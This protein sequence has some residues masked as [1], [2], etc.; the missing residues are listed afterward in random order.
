M[1]AK[2][3]IIYS[4]RR[5]FVRFALLIIL[6]TTTMFV[7]ANEQVPIQQ[8]KKSITTHS[9]LLFEK[10]RFDNIWSFLNPS[11]ITHK[12]L[13]CGNTCKDKHGRSLHDEWLGKNLWEHQTTYMHRGE[14]LYTLAE[15]SAPLDTRVN[16]L[17]HT[18]VSVGDLITQQ[19]DD[20]RMPF[21]EFKNKR[22]LQKGI[23]YGFLLRGLC[24]YLGPDGVINDQFTIPDVI[25][26]V[27]K[28]GINYNTEAGTHEFEGI[29]FCFRKYANAKTSRSFDEKTIASYEM[30]EEFLNKAINDTL[31]NINEDGQLYYLDKSFYTCAEPDELCQLMANLIKQAH[32]FEWALY[33]QYEILDD[34][35]AKTSLKRLNDILQKITLAF[36][37]RWY[38][39]NGIRQGIAISAI[40]HAMHISKLLIAETSDK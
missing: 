26:R 22:E 36:D 11:L 27:I 14:L 38:F 39:K 16:L 40:T 5:T 29:A 1:M 13:A 17:P 15:L 4:V 18:K 34:D 28:T 9:N 30:A 24:H 6:F 19:K 12:F 33:V 3:P 2:L 23:E 20:F 32:F 8:L 7:Q 21:K 25:R 35:R 10:I 31:D 37:K